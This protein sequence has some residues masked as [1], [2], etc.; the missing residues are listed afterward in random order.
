[1]FMCV[2]ICDCILIGHII[3]GMY[4][5]LRVVSS[6]SLVKGGEPWH[7]SVNSK[8]VPNGITKTQIFL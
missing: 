2:S 8:S 6:M 1:M 5:K 7:S 4:T 3:V